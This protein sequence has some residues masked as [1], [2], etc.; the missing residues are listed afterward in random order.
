M[1]P[2]VIARRY[3]TAL[4]EIGV[5]TG[6]LD[7]LVEEIA[8]AAQNVRSQRRAPQR[9]LADPLV[10]IQ[11]KQAILSDFAD[12]LTLGQMAKNTLTM[13][14]DR[15]RIQAIVPIAA[16]LR[17]MAD[18]K[19]GLLRAEVHTAMP[20]PEEY[21]TQLQV[22]QLERVTGRRI[23]LDRKLDPALDLRR[24]RPRGRHR[25][26]TA[27]CFARLRQLKDSDAPE[28]R[29][30]SGDSFTVAEEE[31]K[32]E[33]RPCSS[34]AEEISSIIKKQIQ[35]YERAALTTETRNRPQHRRRHCAASMASKASCPASSSSSRGGL[36]GLALNLEADNV[37]ARA[38]L[39]D[40]AGIKEGA[41]VK[42]TAEPHHGGSPSARPSSA[43][44]STRSGIPVDGKGPLET[45]HKPPRRDQGAGHPPAAPAGQRA[46]PDGDQGDRRDGPDRPRSTRAHHRRPP[47]RQDRGRDRHDHQPE[48]LARAFTASTSRSGQKQSTVAAVVDKLTHH[49]AMEYTTVVI[50][51]A[52]ESAPLQYIAPYTGVTMAEY[53][54]DTGRHALCIYDDLSKQAVAYRQLSLLLRR[55]RRAARRT[56]ATCSTFT[57]VCSSA[58]R[59]SPIASRVV[60]K[61]KKYEEVPDATVHIGEQGHESSELELWKK[62]GRRSR[63]RSGR[64]RPRTSQK[65]DK[66]ALKKTRPQEGRLSGKA[67]ESGF[68]IV[69]DPLSGGSLTALPIIETQAGDVSAYIPT[70]VISITDGQIFLEADLFYSGV[71]P[72]DQRRYLRQP[73]RWQRADQ[74]DEGR[75]RNA[76]ARPRAVPR[77]GGVRAVRL[78]PRPGHA[79]H[80]RARRAPRRD[81][82]AGAVRAASGR[83]ADRH[84]LRR[85]EGLPRLD[86][87]RSS[88]AEYEKGLTS[89]IESKHGTRRSSRRSGQKKALDDDAT[90]SLEKALKVSSAPA[91]ARRLRTSAKATEKKAK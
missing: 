53:F 83:E 17:E 70:N 15:R 34:G 12:K 49:G 52:S 68:E 32:K 85:H 48:V 72:G 20:L 76:E 69:K 37:G 71:R 6:K 30:S 66:D 10:H 62:S 11:V 3:A 35:S 25:S 36:M 46:A 50:A 79:Q 19:R 56:R 60:P 1:I 78:R 42:R 5:E 61:G 81:P 75:R 22:Q 91:S 43:A 9:V 2:G 74:G 8:R 64:P 57:R 58:P 73:R 84:H 54:R 45:P 87:R 67:K 80:A 59:S 33:F 26:T 41:I 55:A 23:A 89:F 65:A 51:G 44:S 18:E 31:E 47:D 27:R 21:F 88:L 40:V 39:G 29:A 63:L 28:L 7:S 13:L 77:E 38:L 86:R 90:K 24:R 14:L 16:R 82:E 4:L